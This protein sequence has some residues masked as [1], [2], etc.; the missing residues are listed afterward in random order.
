MTDFYVWWMPASKAYATVSEWTMKVEATLDPMKASCF[1]SEGEAMH[2][3]EY[4][5]R[6]E[7]WQ[8]EGWDLCLV[9]VRPE[10]EKLGVRP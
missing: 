4:A 9:T 1:D 10:V 3:R 2:F 8:P 6:V 5:H 7:N